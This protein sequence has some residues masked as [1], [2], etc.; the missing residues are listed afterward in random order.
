MLSERE[1][2]RIADEI[3]PTGNGRGAVSEALMIVQESRG[4]LSDEA[5][6]DVADALS[7]TRD[8]VDGVA[9][10]FELLYRRPVGKHVILLCDSV[11]CWLTGGEKILAHI[12][13]RLGVEMGGTSADGLF[14]LL[15]AGCLGACDHG[16]A[17]MVDDGLFGD[18]TPDRVDEILERYRGDGHGDAAHR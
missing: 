6:G 16:P 11:S 2:K 8:E 18:L 3:G 17:M 5:I 14:T 1:R 15:P 7:L 9:T 13:G 12:R 10:F 4:W